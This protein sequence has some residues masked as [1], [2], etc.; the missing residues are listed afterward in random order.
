[1]NKAKQFY[2][3][4]R[5]FKLVRSSNRS[6]SYTNCFRAYAS[7]SNEHIFKK[8]LLWRKLIKEGYKCYTECIFENG[9]GRLDI[10]AVKEGQGFA[11]EI[12]ESET[13]QE[14]IEKLK[15]YLPNEI[16]VTLIKT[17]EDIEN[18]TL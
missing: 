8:F 17:K 18:L 12:L 15:K 5:I 13:E 1:M 10:L 14:C 2:E 16:N 7:E 9:A 3:E 6:G 11:F 4:N